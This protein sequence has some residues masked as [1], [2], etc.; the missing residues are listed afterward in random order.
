MRVFIHPSQAL[1]ERHKKMFFNYPKCRGLMIPFDCQALDTMKRTLQEIIR[2]WSR[3]VNT[4]FSHLIEN[5]STVH[6]TFFL[7]LLCSANY[8]IYHLIMKWISFL[9][10][11][12][13]RRRPKENNGNF[14][15]DSLE[16]S[17][18]IPALTW[19][20]DPLSSENAVFVSGLAARNE[21]WK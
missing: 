13:H 5:V 18:K 19:I 14:I 3:K 7:L 2:E 21:K 1:K 4:K 6:F 9:N 15:A 10:W 20:R 17:K 11:S 16:N 12:R 8:S